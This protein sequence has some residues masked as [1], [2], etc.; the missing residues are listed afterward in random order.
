MI[1]GLLTILKTLPPENKP[2]LRKIWL[3]IG[4]LLAH[5]HVTRMDEHNLRYARLS[6]P[7]IVVRHD[8]V[9]LTRTD[10]TRPFAHS[11][12]FGP[13]LMWGENLDF[14]T[15]LTD[16]ILITTM[17][18]CLITHHNAV[19]VCRPHRRASSR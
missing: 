6:C 18:A 16:S 2:I 4:E 15:G 10:C 12:V 13:M 17:F 5:R 19:L 7:L 3:L 9:Y 11:V 14:N 1:H 8:G